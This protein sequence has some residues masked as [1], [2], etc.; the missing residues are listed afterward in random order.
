MK[1]RLNL[2]AL[3]FV[4]SS[5]ACASGSLRLQNPSPILDMDQS[6]LRAS[7]ENPFPVPATSTVFFEWRVNAPD[8]QLDGDGYAR[9]QDP[10]RARLDLFTGNNEAVLAAS[11]VDDEL[12]AREERA[13]DFVPS[14]ALLWAFLGTFRPGEDATRLD[15]EFD[16]ED[17]RLDYRLPDGD[18]LQY[19]FRS[20]RMTQ[21]EVYHEGHAVHRVR[22]TWE[23]GGEL[24]SEATYRNLASF[25][26]LKV[27]VDTVERVD[28]H[29]SDIWYLG[30]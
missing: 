28:S 21:V 19:L 3:G 11:L 20:G 25:S 29:P 8:L 6:V 7:G 13:L 4:V 18:E 5:T 14:P 1:F 16:G 12:W 30:P 17:V 24:P 26:E 22:L 9:L 10:D 2:V 23:G 15:G 27:T